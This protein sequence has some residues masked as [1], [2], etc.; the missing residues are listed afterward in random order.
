VLKALQTIQLKSFVFATLIYVLLQMGNWVYLPQV[1]TDFGT[2]GAII[3]S[4]NSFHIP[5]FLIKAGI[6]ILSALILA[7]TV[8]KNDVIYKHTALPYFFFLL[9]GSLIP[10]NAFL[11]SFSI[12][13][14]ITVLIFA[15]IVHFHDSDT[16]SY[17]IFKSS[18]LVGIGSIIHL[19]FTP[20]IIAVVFA[21]TRFLPLKFRPIVLL[22]LGSFFPWMMLWAWGY[23]N[24]DII[25][26]IHI[27]PFPTE[28]N[29]PN[30]MT[31]VLLSIYALMIA[32]SSFVWV[33]NSRR[34]TVKSRRL[35][36]IVALLLFLLGPLAFYFVSGTLHSIELICLPG[37]LVLAYFFT[38]SKRIR[39]K[40][41]L[42]FILI[43][44]LLLNQYKEVLSF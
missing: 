44:S 19:S 36:Q 29:L 14:L 16:P 10:S 5:A 9:I 13:S 7:N 24:P 31:I 1:A 21:Y 11:S 8:I 30:T 33:T 18:I 3:N 34:N 20:V 39:I 22:F 28:R 43:V 15:Q 2:L 42:F 35:I 4:T 37:S 6:L 41:I 17:L 32:I 27:Q 23:V 38:S 25:N 12:L 40:N 26:S